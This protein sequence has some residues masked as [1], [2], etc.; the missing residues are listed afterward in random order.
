MATERSNLVSLLKRTFEKE[1]WHGPSVTEALA[2]IEAREAT[3]RLSNTHSIIELVLHMT[4]WREY[5]IQKLAG[6]A[7]YSVTEEHNFPAGHNWPESVQRLRENQQKLVSALESFPGD[8][9]D[10]VPGKTAPLSF[11][12][13]VH[14]II[15]HDL[16]HTGQIMLIK[17]AGR[18][19]TI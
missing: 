18:A 6:N 9:Q 16:Y 8:L 3:W 14:G 13:L 10:Q 5:V 4:A 15:H 11:Y 2:D 17:K 19:Q 7:S 12:T 1:A